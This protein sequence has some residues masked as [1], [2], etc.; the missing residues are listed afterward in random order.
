MQEESRSPYKTAGVTF[1]SFVLVGFIPLLAYVLDFLSTSGTGNL[2][3]TSCIMTS[4]AFG[5][6]GLLKSY[7]T[8]TGKIRGII[9]TLALG[10]L[11]A[12]IAYY[13]GDVLEMVLR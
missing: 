9:E 5:L 7:V 6:I 13:V 12:V 2:F 11:A 8:E 10:G 3:L 1:G 4:V